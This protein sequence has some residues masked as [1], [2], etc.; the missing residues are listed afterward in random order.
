M[1]SSICSDEYLGSGALLNVRIHEVEPL[2]DLNGS[3][4][5]S[6]ADSPDS[7]EYR[8]DVNLREGGRLQRWNFWVV[9][10]W[11]WS[12]ILDLVYITTRGWCKSWLSI[13]TKGLMKWLV[14]LH[15]HKGA[16]VTVGMQHQLVRLCQR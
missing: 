1:T 4:P 9:N 8:D 5:Q 3:N 12:C 7:G 15:H 10:A 11:L 13:T 14:S 16:G 2:V 6:S